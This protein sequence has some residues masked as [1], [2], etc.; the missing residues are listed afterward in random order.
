MRTSRV[1]AIL[2]TGF[3]FAVLVASASAQPNPDK[4]AYFGE[5]H[6]H[7]G[8]SFDAF[9]FGNTKTNP[10]DAYKYAIGEPIK[11][12]AGYD[13][14]IETPLDWMGV[15][16]HSEYV[17][18]VQLANDPNS[19]IAKLPIAEKLKVRDPA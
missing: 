6:V 9:I 12:A 17:G 11:H 2:W 7:T 1:P 13:I 5:T 19:A 15:T 3:A 10:A 8:W 4:D 16:D 14:K 18:V